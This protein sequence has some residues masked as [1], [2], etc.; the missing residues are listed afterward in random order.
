M[1]KHFDT[2][3]REL[4]DKKYLKVFLKDKNKI[5]EV[6]NRLVSLRSVRTANITQN[7]E[8]DLTVYPAKV[9]DIHETK[10]EVE[11]CLSAFFSGKSLL[12]GEQVIEET[13]DLLAN[14][15]KAK[16]IY[17]SAL[18]K[19]NRGENARNVLDDMRLSLETHLKKILNN[20][21]SLENQLSEVGKYIQ[22]K[23]LSKELANM[24]K[25]LLDY[26]AKYQNTYVKHNDAVKEKEVDFIIQQ[27]SSFIR[28]LV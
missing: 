7:S 22:E 4:F 6:R 11:K 26:Y 10:Q 14:S 9:Y 28:M 1:A 17:D 27:T 20:D 3:I 2:E 21:K 19:Y 24:F 16:S 23:G 18:D 25:T 8:M 13:A 5:S 15:P 12:I